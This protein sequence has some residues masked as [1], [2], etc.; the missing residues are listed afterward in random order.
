M[1]IDCSKWVGDVSY[2]DILIGITAVISFGISLYEFISRKIQQNTKVC[3]YVDSDAGFDL[4]H[5]V[6]LNDNSIVFYM[7]CLFVNSADSDVSITRIDLLTFNNELIKCSQRE[8][9][10]YT[11]SDPKHYGNV[12]KSV[13]FPINLMRRQGTYGVL[14]FVLPE[15]IGCLKVKKVYIHTNKRT[16]HDKQFIDELNLAVAKQL[17]NINQ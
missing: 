11:Y 7:P 16:V 4:Y 9:S 8:E 17:K 1:S 14:R 12:A 2:L 5:A 10:F 15:S 3:L 13:R 6:R